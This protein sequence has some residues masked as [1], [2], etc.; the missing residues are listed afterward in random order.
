[1]LASAAQL[2]VEAFAPLARPHR[3]GRS[4]G[5]G[6]AC[7][8]DQD[9]DASEMLDRGFRRGFR[10]LRQ[11]DVNGYDVN[12]V[13]RGQFFSGRGKPLRIA[14]PQTATGAGIEETFGDR[15]AN[16][17]RSPGDDGLLSFEINFVH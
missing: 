5:T 10:R 13:C 4:G 2:A 8:I 15:V 17:A 9:V 14:V 6:A 3:P 11:G 1:P 16:A 7:V 12:F